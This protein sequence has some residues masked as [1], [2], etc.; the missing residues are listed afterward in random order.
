MDSPLFVTTQ[1]ACI[2]PP[3]PNP[4]PQNEG[5]G[6]AFLSL[7]LYGGGI[8]GWGGVVTFSVYHSEQYTVFIMTLSEIAERGG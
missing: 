6:A 5:K 8:T 3:I 4:F 1:A 2:F 7:P